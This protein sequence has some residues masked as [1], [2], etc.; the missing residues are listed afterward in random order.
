[1][2]PRNASATISGE[3][4]VC[5]CCCGA[6]VLEASATT[7][8][9]EGDEDEDERVGV[10]VLACCWACASFC[11]SAATSPAVTASSWG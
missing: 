10:F 8:R 5:C 1:M 9:G 11:C 7:T 4:G 2:T 6:L 3:E